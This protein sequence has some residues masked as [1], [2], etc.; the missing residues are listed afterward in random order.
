[1]RYEVEG[2]LGARVDE[3]FDEFSEE[4]FAAASIGQVHRGRLHDGREVAIKIQ[5]PLIDEIVRADLKNLKRLLGSLF[6][7]IFDIDFE[8]IWGE[9][10]DRL[11]E[12]LDYVHEA[13]NM[14]RMAELHSGVP[15]I[16]IPGVVGELSTQR[17]LT[18]EMVPGIA[19]DEACSSKFPTRLRNE[20]GRVLFEFQMR[21]LFEHRLLHADP[22]LANFAFREDGTV[23]VYDFGCVKRVPEALARGYAGLVRAVLD[24]RR[25]EIPD[26]LLALGVYKKGK[27]PMPVDVVG[28]YVDLF[29]DVLRASPTYEFGEDE[30]FYDR[31]LELG[32]ANWSHSI[33]VH[34]PQDIVF[35][36]RSL[37]GHFGNLT[38]L[39]A[40]GPWRELLAKHALAAGCSTS[41]AEA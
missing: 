33:D 35:I 39:R 22:N 28:P 37:A 4:A 1:M 9:L 12:E 11:L 30:A 34:F 19:P 25:T 8:P 10:R 23:V 18:M 26:I 17:V 24:E 29:A 36:D 14:R 13:Q 31:I 5:Y 41:P 32:A 27:V 40:A 16:V 15:E 2:A 3:L 20:W 6:G 21:G 7:F 38:R